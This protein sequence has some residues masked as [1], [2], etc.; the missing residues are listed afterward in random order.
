M[1]GIGAGPDPALGRVGR[2]VGVDVSGPDGDRY[3]RPSVP[4]IRPTS[5]PPNSAPA[6]RERRGRA[7]RSAAGLVLAVVLGIALTAGPVSARPVQDPVETTIVGTD[8]VD[9]TNTVDTVGTTVVDPVET[10]V[11]GESEPTVQVD[12]GG[13]GS[14]EVDAENRRIWAVVGA[15]VAVAIALTWLTVRYWRHTKPRPVPT[16]AGPPTKQAG[17]VAPAATKAPATSAGT[18]PPIEP[19][20]VD[21]ALDEVAFAPPTLEVPVVGA[22]G[23]E[24]SEAD[25]AEVARAD[26]ARDEAWQPRATGEQDRLV[27]A[28]YEHHVRPTAEQRRAVFA[29]SRGS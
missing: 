28:D 10:T 14:A 27:L 25:A 12:P 18:G 2:R 22:G 4:P 6:P 15:L 29:A 8:S 3:A 26:H 19:L 1:R 21:D 5:T 23:D 17:T 16:P 24:I 7:V 9:T 20:A 11:A 13:P